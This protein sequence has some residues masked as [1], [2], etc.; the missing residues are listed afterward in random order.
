MRVIRACRELGIETVAVYSTADRDSLHVRLADRAVCIGPPAPAESYLNIP[1]IIGAAE[2]TGCEAVHPGLRLPRRERGVRARLRGQRP[3]LH[4]AAARLDRADG[5]QGAGPRDDG[6]RRRA[7]RARLAPALASVAG[8]CRASAAELG[9]P[10]L[11]KASAGGGGRGMRLVAGPEELGR[12]LRRGV[13]R[14]ARRRSRTARSTSRRRSRTRG[15]SRSRCSATARAACSRSESATA[16]SSAAT[17]SS[18]RSR[19]R[20]ASRRRCATRSRRPRAGPARRSATAA[21]GTIEFLASGD[22]FFFIE[23]NT[24][25]QVEHPVTELVTG[26]RS[27]ARAARGCRGRGPS[28]HRTGRAA[29]GTRSR[30]GS[31]R[32]IPAAASCRRPARRRASG[33]RSAP[34]SASTPMSSRATPCRRTT[35]P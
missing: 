21:P 19:R 4:R 27:R 9:Y 7:D 17:R 34:A 11:L 23:M 1:S 33:R 13:G 6:R 15:T 10:V 8:R 14:G 29:T 12:R 24:R 25:L 22:E 3:R 18:S 28:A 20:P 35:T 16:R 26:H 30:S 5:R 32:R 2:T 31:T